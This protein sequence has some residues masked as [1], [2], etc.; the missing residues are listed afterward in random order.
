MR[1]MS[2][3]LKD[4]LYERLKLSIPSK[5][6]SKFVCQAIEHELEARE[7]ALSSAYLEAEK[8]MERQELIRE[9]EEIDDVK[10]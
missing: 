2:I 4:S 10:K 3:S 6:I 5:K 8:D 1:T 7:S 9:W